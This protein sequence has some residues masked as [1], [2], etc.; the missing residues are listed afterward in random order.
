[1]LFSLRNLLRRE[2]EVFTAASG[3]E[4]I[5]ILQKQAIHVVMTDQR[6]PQ[7]TG[8]QFLSQIKDDHPEAI[9]MIFTG[10]A[11]VSAV[12]DAINQGNVYRYVTKPWDPEDLLTA[13]RQAGKLYDLVAARRKLLTDLKGYEA[14]CVAMAE[15]MRAGQ[16]GTLN[17]RG[18]AEADALARQGLD[19]MQRVDQTLAA[20]PG[21]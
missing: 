20:M 11:D 14:R 21:R 10:Y 15:A 6:M 2:F 12:I 1:M 17:E 13:L 18:A 8:V 4:G 5:E 7:M 19:L 16:L 3:A 9:R